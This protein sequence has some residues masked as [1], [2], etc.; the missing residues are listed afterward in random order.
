MTQER[1]TLGELIEKEVRRQN[2]SITDFADRIC[3]QRGNV[4]DIFKRGDKIDAAQLT[5]ISRVLKHN[6]FKDLAED[7]NLINLENEEIRKDMEDRR[8]VSQFMEVIPDILIKM[9]I[10]P[11]IVFS[12]LK[13]VLGEELPDFGLSDYPIT[14]TIGGRLWD[15]I[16]DDLK[17]ELEVESYT[18]PSGAIIDAWINVLGHTVTIDIPIIY[19]NK[20]EWESIINFAILEVVPRYGVLCDFHAPRF[21]RE[22]AYNE[23]KRM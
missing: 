11:T 15:K 2:I 14:F 3:C 6:F 5:L 16:K 20:E 21:L 7:S 17:A 18:T 8:A 9:D 19:H 22:I 12:K 1:L 4:Y 23:R 10:E 13:K